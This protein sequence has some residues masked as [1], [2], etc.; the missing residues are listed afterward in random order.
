MIASERSFSIKMKEQ[1][2]NPYK[3]KVKQS[4]YKHGQVLTVSVG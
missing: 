1:V 3:A 2:P 4:L